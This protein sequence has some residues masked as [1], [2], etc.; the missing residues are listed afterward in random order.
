[1]RTSL[2]KRQLT[3]RIS[4]WSRPPRTSA[5]A[6]TS[7]HLAEK[8]VVD[9][10]RLARAGSC[11]LVSQSIAVAY[12]P[13]CIQASRCLREAELKRCRYIGKLFL[14]STFLFPPLYA[15]FIAGRVCKSHRFL[16]SCF[17]IVLSPFRSCPAWLLNIIKVSSL[18]FPPSQFGRTRSGP[19]SMRQFQRT[20]G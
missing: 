6:H 3:S 2:A 19:I 8:D 18:R 20:I 4:A 10:N 12:P 1:M 13:E 17:S 16:L 7:T 11:P 5:I 15:S 14:L 9:H